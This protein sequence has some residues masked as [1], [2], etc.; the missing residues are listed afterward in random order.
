MK[1]LLLNSTLLILMSMAACQGA[2]S[3][4]PEAPSRGQKRP[5]TSTSDSMDD[6]SFHLYRQTEGVGYLQRQMALPLSGHAIPL[7]ECLGVPVG[8][9]GLDDLPNKK[10]HEDTL[11]SAPSIGL[12]DKAPLLPKEGPPLLDAA[13][14]VRFN[15]KAGPVNPNPIKGKKRS[16]EEEINTN[17]SPCRIS[18]KKV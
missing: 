7:N 12:T 14:S 4:D 10:F 11:D 16:P 6:L 17:P 15:F 5:C 13:D 9:Y 18:H 2:S 1:K 3:G 8:T